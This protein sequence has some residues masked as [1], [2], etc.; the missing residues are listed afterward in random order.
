MTALLVPPV[1]TPL[2]YVQIPA[3]SKHTAT[4]TTC[5]GNR[6]TE[7]RVGVFQISPRILPEPGFVIWRLQLAV[8]IHRNSCH[9][10]RLRYEPMQQ[11]TGDNERQAVCVWQGQEVGGTLCGRGNRD[12]QSRA[13]ARVV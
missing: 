12:A 5:P 8:L 9:E 4:N 7:R 6:R 1:G 10:Q 2:V 3:I 11:D 13:F